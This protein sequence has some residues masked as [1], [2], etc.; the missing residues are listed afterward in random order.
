MSRGASSTSRS[1]RNADALAC[2][3]SAEIL[4]E[5]WTEGSPRIVGYDAKWT[6]ESEAYTGTPRRFGLGEREPALAAEL[7]KLA[8]SCWDL[9]N[10]AGYARVD[11][12]VDAQAS[13]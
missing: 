1:W 3:P 9:F 6:A 2:C 12:R 13:P 7:E 10:L 5:D 11:F 4:F 8:K